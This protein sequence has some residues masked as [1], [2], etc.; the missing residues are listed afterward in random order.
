MVRGKAVESP[1]AK[2]L[3][4]NIQTLKG[5][6]DIVP[7]EQKYWNLIRAAVRDFSLSYSFSRIDLPIMEAKQL[8]IKGLGKSSPIVER[9][10]YSFVDPEGEKIA[11]RPEATVSVA[12]AYVEH[13]MA[14]QPQP[15]KLFYEGPMFRCSGSQVVRYRQFH[16]YGFEV[17]GSSNPLLDAQVIFINYRILLALGLVTVVNINS[18]GC[19]ECRP[20]Y[21][22]VLTAYLTS[23]IMNQERPLAK[24]KRSMENH[25]KCLFYLT[26]L[27]L[28]FQE[29]VMK[30]T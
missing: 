5:M 17:L 22:K 8:F 9:D 16:Q 7:E 15:V 10:M 20:S 29:K 6:R 1:K 21:Q 12:R 26:N 13:G 30:E 2:K 24:M 3:K 23:K 4:K 14:N 28:N 11:L 18:M 25:F 19:S 27:I